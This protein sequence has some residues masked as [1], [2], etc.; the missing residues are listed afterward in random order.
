MADVTQNLKVRLTAQDAASTEFAKVG[1][2]AAAAAKNTGVLEKSMLRLQQ[3]AIGVFSVALVKKVVEYAGKLGEAADK[4]SE[5][6]RA[7][8][9][10]K[11]SFAGFKTAFDA[12]FGGLLEV[13]LP[14]LA[15][16]FDV[17]NFSIREVAEAIGLINGA[18]PDKGAVLRKT[19]EDL[20]QQANAVLG[21]I[22]SAEQRRDL[23]PVSNTSAGALGS[24]LTGLQNT[25]PNSEEAIASLREEYTRLSVQVTEASEAL[26]K[27]NQAQSAAAAEAA[28]R[29]AP[30]QQF[31]VPSG[32]RFIPEPEQQ[33]PPVDQRQLQ[34]N[35]RR[36]QSLTDRLSESWNTLTQ[37]VFNFKE[38]ASDAVLAV[39]TSLENNL[40]TAIESVVNGTKSAK[41]AFADFAKSVVAD[42]VSVSARLLTVYIL[43]S[44]TGISF[45]GGALHGG[46]FG[47]GGG[48]SGDGP[49]LR[50]HH[51]MS[52]GIA[53]G[54]S[55][56]IYAEGSR[57]EAFV[58]LDDGKTIPVSIRSRGGQAVVNNFYIDA[59]DQGSVQRF[60]IENGDTILG[61]GNYA[62]T[63]SRT[64]REATRRAV[65]R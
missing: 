51:M 24:A 19:V 35:L 44:L 50:L 52:G 38:A 39:G 12:A 26:L 2:S 20:Q 36:S 55:A 62:L 3:L 6:G 31:N 1:Q 53:R 41:E 63:H 49:P 46:I 16:G 42:L 32:F 14:K 45:G 61:I 11:A 56:V 23:G 17:L 25:L 33:G 28:A 43:E 22:R 64:Q 30:S 5:L 13:I 15:A 29:A 37:R 58:P 65:R 21:A 34:E 54:P 4:T 9:A 57:D 18:I 7:N 8:E 60:F 10:F 27:F 40:S 48:S 47:G 59:I